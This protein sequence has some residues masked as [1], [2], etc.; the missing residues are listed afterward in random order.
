MSN[1]MGMYSGTIVLYFCDFAMLH[2]MIEYLYM[3]PSIHTTTS[4]S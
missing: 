4:T 2:T 1:E 3:I